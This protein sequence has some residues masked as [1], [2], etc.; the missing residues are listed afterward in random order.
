M[1]R[2]TTRVPASRFTNGT[3]AVARPETIVVEEPLEIRVDGESVVVTM[4]TPGDDVDLAF[5]LLLAEGVIESPD[6]VHTAL[7]CQDLGEDGRPTFNVLDLSRRAGLPAVDLSGRRTFGMSSACGVCGSAVIEAIRTRQRLAE[8][9]DDPTSIPVDLL[10]ELPERM[11]AAQAVFARTGGVHA[12]GLFTPDGELVAIREDVGRHN[13]TDKVI[14]HVART[15]GWPLPRLI[16]V[17]SGR[18][19]FE[20][21]QKAWVAGI[22]IIGAVSAGSSMAVETAEAAG[23]TLAGF[24]R[25]PKLVC[26]TRPDR[27]LSGSVVA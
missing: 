18:I 4:R 23:I 9:A 19:S 17:L 24:V 15:L 6:E 12:A 25:P 26:Y 8:I 16:L 3:T 22:P 10:L 14:G 20:L 5:G 13:A 27:L 11:R 21:V 7:H 1:G 2:V